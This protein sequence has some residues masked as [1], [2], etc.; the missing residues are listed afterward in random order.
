MVSP[1]NLTTQ[2]QQRLESALTISPTLTS[3]QSAELMECVVNH[4][5]VFALDDGEMGE[6]IGV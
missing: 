6:V 2:R 3:K 5:D 4:H 1:G